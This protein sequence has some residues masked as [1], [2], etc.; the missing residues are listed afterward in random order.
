MPSTP[1][2]AVSPRDCSAVIRRET[3]AEF[4][5]SL[6]RDAVV[7]SLGFARRAEMRHVLAAA[8]DG[9]PGTSA[10]AIAG[11]SLAAGDRS[12]QRRHASVSNGPLPRA[13]IRVD[14]R[15]HSAG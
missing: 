15:K 3:P 12:T 11:H 14:T 9:T 1:W 7:A 13:S 6:V 10:S 4:T 8:M 5:H 2:T